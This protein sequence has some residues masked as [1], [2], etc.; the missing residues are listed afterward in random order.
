MAV[1]LLEDD[2]ENNHPSH[3]AVDDFLSYVATLPENERKA[4]D[5]LRVPAVDNHTGLP[6][7]D[8]IGDAVRDAKGNRICVH[9]AGDLLKQAA[10]F[11]N[12]RSKR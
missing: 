4:I 8:T 11:L 2:T 10:N 5:K 7:D 1:I 9:K 12:S 3:A 6:F